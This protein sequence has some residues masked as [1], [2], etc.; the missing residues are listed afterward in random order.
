MTVVSNGA[1]DMLKSF[2]SFNNYTGFGIVLT[3]KRVGQKVFIKVD[4]IKEYNHIFDRTIYKLTLGDQ[5]KY[6]SPASVTDA[7]FLS[8]R[9]LEGICYDKNL[10]V[11]LNH[12]NHLLFCILHSDSSA[13]E[14]YIF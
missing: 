13:K 11:I 10:T 5:C 9:L 3:V 8:R 4:N 14:H 7:P 6:M 1:N 2:C 12:G